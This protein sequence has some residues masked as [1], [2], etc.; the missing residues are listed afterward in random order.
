MTANVTTLRTLTRDLIARLDADLDT[1]QNADYPDDLMHE[2]VD[3]T[4]P[5]YNWELAECLADNPSLADVEDRG[6]L[7]ENANVWQIL[8]VS[9]SEQLSYVAYE[10][11]EENFD[12]GF[13]NA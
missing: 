3:S 9:I 2:Y 4:V 11:L 13:D 1:I 12:E 10:W 8:R 6:L 5:V 7:S